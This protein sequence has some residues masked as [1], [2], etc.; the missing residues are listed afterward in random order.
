MKTV[1]LAVITLGGLYVLVV[2]QERICDV[3]TEYARCIAHKPITA[4]RKLGRCRAVFIVRARRSSNTDPS[5]L[6]GTLAI[7]HMSPDSM[8]IP[9]RMRK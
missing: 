3:Q 9:A 1:L 8:S 2:M 6:S 4:G 7:E 5:R